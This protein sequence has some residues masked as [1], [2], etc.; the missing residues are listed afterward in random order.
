MQSYFNRESSMAPAARACAGMWRCPS[1]KAPHSAARPS[2]RWNL[3][4]LMIVA[5]S[6]AL[7]GGALISFAAAPGSSAPLARDDVFLIEWDGTQHELDVLANDSG[8]GDLVVAAVG[9]TSGSASIRPDEDG[10][11]ILFWPPGEFRGAETFT[12]T[13]VDGEGRTSTGA[14]KVT[15]Q[16]DYVLTGTKTWAL[17]YGFGGG[18]LG[19]RRHIKHAVSEQDP[20]NQARIHPSYGGDK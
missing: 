4:F 20:D 15:E 9:P 2:V 1:R 14:V 17:S 16:F 11:L 19:G 5:C 8:A 12:Y 7:L 13:L 18:V 6:A 10:R 3:S